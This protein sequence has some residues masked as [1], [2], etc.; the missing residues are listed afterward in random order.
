MI[1]SWVRP[2]AT[3][4][5]DHVSRF[6]AGRQ[7]GQVG[8]GHGSKDPFEGCGKGPN[9]GSVA[10]RSISHHVHVTTSRVAT[11]GVTAPERRGEVV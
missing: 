11:L 8:D 7:A 1:S 10:Y 6:A 9:E 4:S 3:A 2:S 5:N